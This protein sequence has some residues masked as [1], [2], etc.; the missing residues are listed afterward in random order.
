VDT[1][2]AAY[3]VV[4]DE[5]RMLLVHW[6]EGALR[7]WSLPGGGLEPGEHPEAAVVREVREE[8]GYDVVVDGLTGVESVVYPS[9]ERA[10]PDLPDLHALGILYRAHVVGGALAHEVDGSTDEAVWVP[11][12]DVDALDRVPLVDAARRAAGL[13][14]R[15]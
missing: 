8:T 2:V 6:S 14:V 13:L 3:A 7:G 12:D 4:V 9:A 15:D 10:H 5:G 1:R 11:L